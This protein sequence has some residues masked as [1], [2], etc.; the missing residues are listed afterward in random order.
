MLVIII[1]ITM[2]III[3]LLLTIIMI[4]T[5]IIITIKYFFLS[6]VNIIPISIFIHLLLSIFILFFKFYFNT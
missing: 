3:I 5:T 4:T 2:N 6:C 1:K